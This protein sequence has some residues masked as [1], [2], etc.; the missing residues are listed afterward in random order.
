MGKKSNY[1]DPQEGFAKYLEEIGS[2][3]VRERFLSYVK[4]SDGCWEWTGRVTSGRYGSFTIKG[5]Q[6][7][8]HRVSYMLF[9]G[10]I[11]KGLNICHE[12]DNVKCVRPSHLWPGTQTQNIY[13]MMSKGR[14]VKVNKSHCPQGH[15]Y[16]IENTYVTT[17]VRPGWVQRKCKICDRK[18][19]AEFRARKKKNG[20]D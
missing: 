14:H 2:E 8:S 10:N 9:K 5:R 7:G 18:R 19:S 17:G 4:K 13:D 16:S 20:R 12:C 1:L 11:P 3:V 6:Y 15:E